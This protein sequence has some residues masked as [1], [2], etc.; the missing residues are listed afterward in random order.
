MIRV[1]PLHRNERV[2]MVMMT[3]V[4]S[5]SSSPTKAIVCISAGVEAKSFPAREDEIDKS[6][7]PHSK[8]PEQIHIQV[9]PRQFDC[10]SSGLIRH[11]EARVFFQTARAALAGYQS[12]LAKLC[13]C[14][15]SCQA[16]RSG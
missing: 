13:I 8:R 9:P 15:L 5:T 2:A 10:Q 16:S 3:N 7:I 1:S 6:G 4:C 14:V 11:P 12:P